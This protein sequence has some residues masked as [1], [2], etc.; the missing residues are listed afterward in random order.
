M[1]WGWPM[2]RYNLKRIMLIMALSLLALFFYITREGQNPSPNAF[3]GSGEEYGL[4]QEEIQA[5]DGFVVRL[6]L[7]QGLMQ[8][9]LLPSAQGELASGEDILSESVGLMLQYYVKT[10]QQEA[11]M[12]HLKLANEVLLKDNGL[13]QWRYRTG[14]VVAVSAAVDDLRI[15][16]ALLLAS[17]KW[18]A[19]AYKQQ[20]LNLAEAVYRHSTEANLLLA[21]DQLKAQPAPLFYYDM[22]TLKYL[23]AI[24]DKW[25]PIL[26]EAKRM[27]VK[28]RH[29][30][31]PFYTDS[32]DPQKAYRMIENLLI[33]LYLSESGE[34]KAGDMKWYKEQL[35]KGTVYA[36]Y[37]EQGLASSTIESPAIY[38][39]LAQIAKN[40][41]DRS[42][43]QLACNKLR[44]MQ[45]F[46]QDDYMGGFIN[47]E[48]KEAYSFDQLMALLGY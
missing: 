14:Q 19:P 26:Q 23:A 42:L 21:Y 47:A 2:K 10:N 25:Q 13:Y 6:F 38:G 18:E 29:A 5:L 45:H 27:L 16:K 24:D 44:S 8:T 15:V 31:L 36:K 33:L 4:Y 43:Y 22:A 30:A 35:L 41:N 40:I 3:I 7:K 48:S 37:D 9:N 1:K 17:E 28:Q 32:Q 39:L 12:A 46:E 11:F 20:A 34:L